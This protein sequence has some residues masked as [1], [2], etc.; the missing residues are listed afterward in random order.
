MTRDAGIEQN[1][2][3]LQSFHKQSCYRIH[4]ATPQRKLFL[5]GLWFRTFFQVFDTYPYRVTEYK[6]SD[7]KRDC[8]RIRRKH[9]LRTYGTSSYICIKTRLEIKF[10][11]RLTNCHDWHLCFFKKNGQEPDHLKRADLTGVSS[12]CTLCFITK[13]K[14]VFFFSPQDLKPLVQRSGWRHIW[15]SHLLLGNKIKKS[16]KTNG[17]M[18]TNKTKET[19]TNTA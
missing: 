15:T 16:L 2:G 14:T 5:A 6:T 7:L 3:L 19:T 11:L 12:R 17:I 1:T 18:A 8:I 4:R 13:F 10:F 9:M